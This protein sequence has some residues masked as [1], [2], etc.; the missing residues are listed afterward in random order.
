MT[1]KPNLVTVLGRK[2]LNFGD[3]TRSRHRF[4]LRRLLYWRR[5][6]FSPPIRLK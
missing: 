6:S 1:T 4:W 3:E 5:D 2:K